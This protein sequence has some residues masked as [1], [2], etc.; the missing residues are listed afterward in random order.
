MRLH[1]RD[2]GTP[3][4]DRADGKSVELAGFPLTALPTP[5]ADHFLL[6]AEP[7]CCAGCVPANR[8]AVV[9]VF[10]DQPLKLGTGQLRLTGTWRIAS[11]AGRLAL[12]A[13]WRRGETRRH[14]P[15]P[16]GGE[17]ALLPAGGAGD[18]AGR[19]HGG[20]HPQPRRQPDP[21]ELRSRP[22]RGG[23]RADAPGRRVGDLSCRRLRFADHQDHGRPSAAGPRSAAGRALRLH[24]AVFPADP[25]AGRHSAVADPQDG[26]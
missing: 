22:V 26:S 5:T 12:P 9:E 16:D 17:P 20:R 14:A 4:A 13:A 25:C 15:C 11:D 1:W 24:P 23:G 2:L 18:G 10:A 8:L 21:D 3:R 19:R 7:G 6:M